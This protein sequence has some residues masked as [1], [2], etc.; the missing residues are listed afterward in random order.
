MHLDPI[1]SMTYHGSGTQ[2][3]IKHCMI[4]LCSEDGIVQNMTENVRRILGLTHKR[5]REEEEILGRNLKIDD[6]VVNFSRIETTITNN[7]LNFF[8]NQ[9]VKVRNFRGQ[10]TTNHIGGSDISTLQCSMTYEETV[11]LK[12]YPGQF[13]EKVYVLI[14]ATKIPELIDSGSGTTPGSVNYGL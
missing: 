8:P 13:S 12:N 3:S 6:L 2:I 1:N 5:V 14:P 11:Y 7:K 9:P 10:A 4:I